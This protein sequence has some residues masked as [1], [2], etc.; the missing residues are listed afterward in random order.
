MGCKSTFSYFCVIFGKG[1]IYLGTYQ[2]QLTILGQIY[3]TL[4][5]IRVRGFPT[6]LSYL[7]R[8][9]IPRTPALLLQTSLPCYAGHGTGMLRVLAPEGHPLPTSRDVRTDGRGAL[10]VPGR[11]R[12]VRGLPRQEYRRRHVL[13]ETA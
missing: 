7:V 1:S 13:R 11:D 12:R 2:L 4:P 6:W 9:T 8:A 3:W 5:H 10:S